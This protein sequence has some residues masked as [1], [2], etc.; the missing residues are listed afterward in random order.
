MRPRIPRPTQL[1]NEKGSW[2]FRVCNS[3]RS[4]ARGDSGHRGRHRRC[5]GHSH[6]RCHGHRSSLRC[7]FCAGLTAASLQRKGSYRC[8]AHCCQ[9]AQELHDHQTKRVKRASGLFSLLEHGCS[10]K[11]KSPWKSLRGP[12]CPMLNP[13]K[14]DLF[15]TG[16]LGDIYF[17]YHKWLRLYIKK[18]GFFFNDD[19]FKLGQAPE[20]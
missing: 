15:L 1:S 16:S 19:A 11:S 7:G 14:Y 8:Q 4:S 17:L 6:G 5:H 20:K 18:H 2:L 10:K 9:I 3:S 13:A 12:T